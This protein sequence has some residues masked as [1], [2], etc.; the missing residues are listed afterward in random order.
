M[1]AMLTP[2]QLL[3][4][5]VLPRGMRKDRTLDAKGM[6]AVLRELAENHPEQYRDVSFKLM[7]VAQHAAYTSGGH[8]CG[9]EHLL[10]PPCVLKL[11]AQL[12]PQLQAVYDDDSLS[13]DERNKKI[14]QLAGRAAAVQSDQVLQ[15]SEAEHNPLAYQIISGAR[16]SK[17]NLTS[18]RGSDML[19]N[20]HRGRVIPI[21]VLHSYSE[22]L[23][24]VEYWAGTYGARKG[25]MDTKFATQ[26]AG[27]LGKQL[28]QIV[29]R[30]LVTGLDSEKPDETLRGLP[31][32][33]NDSESEGSLLAAPVAGFRRNAIV[34]P[35]MLAAMRQKG[36]KR[37]LVRSPA[38][39]GSPD[40]GIYARDAGVREEGRLPMTG[41]NVGLQAAQALSEPLAQGG[42]SSRHSGGVVGA[43]AAKAVSGFDT[44]NQLIQVPKTF[45]GGASHARVDGDVHKIE[46]AP[47]GGTYVHINGERHYVG[48]GYQLKVKRGD[49]VEAGDVLSEGL[50]NPGEVVEHKGIGEGRRYFVETARQAFKD[51]GIKG[52]RR[53]IEL[54]AR[55]LINHV[56]LTDEMG[57]YA[58]DDIVPYSVMEHAYQPRPGH[59][60][61]PPRAAVGQYLEKP[62]LH[63][64]IGTKIRPSMLPDFE[65]FHVRS[66]AVHKDPP[67][68][69]PEM[70]RGMSNLSHDPDWLVRMYGSG[71]KSSLLDSVHHG[72]VSDAKGTSF[73]PGLARAVD[74]GRIGK[75]ITPRE[76]PL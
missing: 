12:Q 21:P 75:V 64:S 42:L 55:G 16:G 7:Q 63:Y 44:I 56:R 27:F 15:E 35:K 57:D 72:G 33:V 51:A 41:S 70:I 37:F 6:K 49:R 76:D 18:L 43:S 40:G 30:S 60:L 32:D 1:P 69:Q 22:G 4:D 2:G 39:S 28:N 45:K 5:S 74:F 23:S 31:V 38:V 66:V 58:P 52:H 68:F 14:I 13:D 65:E 62:Y 20:D 71:L 67:P 11:R 19:Y 9:P 29:H 46:E 24:P 47:A 17:Q 73:V 8:S 26:D 10:P 25:T 48:E 34:S 3:I 53:N 59:E 50:P 54:L 36:I 61:R